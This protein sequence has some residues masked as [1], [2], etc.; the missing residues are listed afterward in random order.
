MSPAISIV[1]TI[2]TT[3]RLIQSTP[4]TAFCTF[5]L[6]STT[7]RF[8]RTS[9]QW[10]DGETSW[11]TVNSFRGLAEHAKASFA[12]GDRVVVSGRMRVRQ[13]EK[14]GRSGVSVE[15]EADA[16]GHDLRWGTTEF[17]PDEAGA[18]SGPST[19]PPHSERAGTAHGGL[20][21]GSAGQNRDAHTPEHPSEPT[22]PTLATETTQDT[23]EGV[24][25]FTGTG[26]GEPSSSAVQHMEDAA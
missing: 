6:A 5:R 26:N 19:V 22:E 14:D 9:G 7:R 17:T 24:G 12:R 11:Y 13:W 3:P 2:G 20:D 18:P 1:G 15:V 10:S 16:L 8:D 25:L 23:D 21:S 4:Q